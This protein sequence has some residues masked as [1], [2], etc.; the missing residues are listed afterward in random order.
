MKIPKLYAQTASKRT[1]DLTLSVNPLGCSPRVLKALSLIS[2]DDIATYPNQTEVMTLLGKQ[3]NIDKTNLLLGSGSEQLI[4]LIAQTFCLKKSRVVVES[5]SF[6]LFTKEF[7]LAGAQVQYALLEEMLVM[8]KP[9]IIILANPKTP[10]GEVIDIKILRKLAIHLAPNLLVIDEANGEFLKKSFISEATK[11]PNVLILRT[12]SKAIGL[13]GLRIGF[14]V[15]SHSLIEK[16]TNVQQPFPVSQISLKLAAVAIKDKRFIDKT[17]KF[18]ETERSFLTRQLKKRKIP[19]SKSMTNNL[20]I[21][22]PNATNVIKELAKRGVSVI[23]SSFF[24]DMET[25]GFRISLK[26]KKTN[27][28]FLKN[29]D[30]ALACIDKNKLLPSKEIT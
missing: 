25:S 8:K 21:K 24:P 2:M 27:R 30:L 7:L 3:F 18:I 9:N 14:V 5:G 1:I 11:L 19:V 15:G 23:D 26:D 4:K 17:K 20:F 16:L 22:V 29:L 6:A 10:T 12:L 28:L 13:A